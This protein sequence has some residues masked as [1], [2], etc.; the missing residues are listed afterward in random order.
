MAEPCF[1]IDIT[2]ANNLIAEWSHIARSIAHQCKWRPQGK[3]L[4]DCQ[5][6]AVCDLEGLNLVDSQGRPFRNPKPKT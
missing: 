4:V 6:L 3:C 5:G 1:E 2:R